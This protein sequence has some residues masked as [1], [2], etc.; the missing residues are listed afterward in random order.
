MDKME[1]A[2]R[3]QH[4]RYHTDAT[5]KELKKQSANRR[6]FLRRLSLC[7]LNKVLNIQKPRRGRPRQ[8]KLKITSK[9]IKMLTKILLVKIQQFRLGQ[10]PN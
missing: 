6:H 9:V 8:S 3:Y 2:R 1:K 5:F 7:L 4:G 10:Y